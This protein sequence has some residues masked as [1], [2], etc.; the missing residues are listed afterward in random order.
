M[1]DLGGG[2]KSDAK[3]ALKALEIVEKAD[4]P[5]LF[6]LKDLHVFFGQHRPPEAT[7]VI[8]KIRDLVPVL[9]R[10]PQPKNVVLVSP[11]ATLP[12]ELEKDV[13]I[14]D[15][16]LPGEEEIRSVLRE[17]IDVNRASGRIVID[18]QPEDEKRLTTAALGLTLQE[19][20]NAFARAMVEDGRL[21]V[22]DVDVIL[23]EKRQVIKKTQI[24]EF[25]Q[26]DVSFDEVGGLQNL[27][28]W[29]RMSRPPWNFVAAILGELSQ[30]G[31]AATSGAKSGEAVIA[32]SRTTSRSTA[33]ASLARSR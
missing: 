9:K 1:T 5:S 18:L 3:T 8:R 33:R 28:R 2:A 10:S 14:L 25:M 4:D 30:T 31:V 15:F 27:K 29:L 16:D 20:E 24:L 21:D 19:A 11:T 12:H 6:I 17:M 26:S 7:Q 23:E 13:T 22:S 32:G